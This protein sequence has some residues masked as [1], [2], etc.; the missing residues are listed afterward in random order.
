M[1]A[2]HFFGILARNV[3][4]PKLSGLSGLG[5]K[6]ARTL[7][8]LRSLDGLEPGSTS[9]FPPETALRQ[10]RTRPGPVGRQ[11]G[12]TEPDPNSLYRVGNQKLGR[13]VSPEKPESQQVQSGAIAFS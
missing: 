3:L 8:P 13:S 2:L 11:A 6:R 10:I 9:C 7:E 5:V 1:A 4:Y 12:R